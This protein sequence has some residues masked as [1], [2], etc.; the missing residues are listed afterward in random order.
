MDANGGYGRH[1]RIEFTLFDGTLDPAGGTVTP[2]SGRHGHGLRFNA[3]AAEP[4]R[5]R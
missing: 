5:D 4:Y 3:D 1:V 2:D